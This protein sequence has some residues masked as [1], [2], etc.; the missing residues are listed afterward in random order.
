LP[1]TRAQFLEDPAKQLWRRQFD[2]Y[3][4]FIQVAANDNY[5][6]DPL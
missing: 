6:R 2:E 5:R 1:V 4:T 3:P